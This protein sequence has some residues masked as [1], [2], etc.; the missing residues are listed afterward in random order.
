MSPV[1]EIHWKK[2]SYPKGGEK[3]HLEYFNFV[4]K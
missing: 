4:K 1:A 3:T 2:K